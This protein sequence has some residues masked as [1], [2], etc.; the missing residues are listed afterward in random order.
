MTHAPFL[1]GAGFIFEKKPDFLA[2][3]G[4]GNRF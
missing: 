2:R 3:M 1:P 4:I